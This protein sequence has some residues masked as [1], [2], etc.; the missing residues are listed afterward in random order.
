MAAPMRE[1]GIATSG[2][3]AVRTEPMKR[4]T[5]NATIIMVSNSVLEISL[6]A[7]RMNRVP[8]H[9]SRISM[10]LGSV[11]RRRSISCTSRCW[12]SISLAPT[13]G[14]TPR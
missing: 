3:R 2:T 1:T 7:S 10:S 6:S 11:G 14:H 5:A 12:T 9:T 13:S 8:S 4:N